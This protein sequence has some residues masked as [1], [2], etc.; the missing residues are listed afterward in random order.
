MRGRAKGGVRGGGCSPRALPAS[1]CHKG[2][3]F[4]CGSCPFLGK[5]A[6]AA[7][8]GRVMLSAG[9]DI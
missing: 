6:F 9:D 1:Q 8:D 2:D 7:G 4:R 3:A 5:P